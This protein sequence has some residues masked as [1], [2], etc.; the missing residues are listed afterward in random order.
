MIGIT[1]VPLSKSLVSS[2]VTSK[3]GIKPFSLRVCRNFRTCP[4]ITSYSKLSENRLYQARRYSVLSDECKAK[5]YNYEDIKKFVSNPHSDK[6]LIDVREPIEYQQGHIPGSINIPF[7]SNPGALSLT[8]DDFEENFGF[9]KP[10]TKKELVFYCLG[11]VRSTAAEDLAKTFG[12]TKRGNYI[13]S[14][15]DWVTNEI[16]NPDPQINK[17]NPK[18]IPSS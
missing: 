15:E 10:D 6:M 16:K 8:P 3:S 9:P 1:R 2:F 7:K 13:G 5:V 14:Y 4:S 17:P 18:P 12:Y 11:G